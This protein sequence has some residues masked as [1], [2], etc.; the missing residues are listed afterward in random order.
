MTFSRFLQAP[1]GFGPV[2]KVLQNEEQMF[3]FS[4]KPTQTRPADACVTDNLPTCT[5]GN[6]F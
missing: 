6:L 2:I 1:T 4:A 5:C 3:E